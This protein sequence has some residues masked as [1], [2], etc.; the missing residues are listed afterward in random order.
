MP[1]P[2]IPMPAM[3]GP[4]ARA[5]QLVTAKL[6]A[7]QELI[8]KLTPAPVNKLTS[9]GNATTVRSLT[10]QPYVS[11]TGA[12]KPDPIGN[13]IQKNFNFDGKV[14]PPPAPPIM[15]GTKPNDWMKSVMPNKQVPRPMDTTIVEQEEIK[16]FILEYLTKRVSTKVNLGNL[17]SRQKD[18]NGRSR[19]LGQNQRGRYVEE[20][21]N[22]E[23]M[24]Y[25]DM[26]KELKKRGYEPHT[27]GRHENWKHHKS[28]HTVPVP[29]HPGDIPMGTARA[30]LKQ[31]GSTRKLEES[32]EQI[33][34]N[35]IRN[36][37]RKLKN[38]ENIEGGGRTATGSSGDAVNVN[39]QADILKGQTR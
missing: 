38:E 17:P 1:T 15:P 20:D 23:E 19:P 30:I 14:P 29:R 24:T 7:R 5:R 4:M 34:Q 22:I 25:R 35:V 13:I 18:M 32:K 3:A 21:E 16:N 37:K 10:P 8:N 33:K 28:G 12:N 27:H 2:P 36:L 11:P 39:P 31:I 6:N 26:T 9:I